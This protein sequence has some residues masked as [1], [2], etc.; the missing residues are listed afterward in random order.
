MIKQMLNGIITLENSLAVKKKNNHLL[1]TIQLS[2]ISWTV[3]S[4]GP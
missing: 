3:K 1:P 2:Q 4:S